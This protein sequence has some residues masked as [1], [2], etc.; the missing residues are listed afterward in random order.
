[1]AQAYADANQMFG[2]IVKVTP[3]S[4]VVGDMALMMVAQ[5]LSRAQVEDPAVDVA[6]PDSVADMLRGNLGQPPGGWPKAI[7]KKVLKGEKAAVD[8]PGKHLAAVDLEAARTNLSKE[9]LGFV[10]DDEDLNGYLMYPKVFLDYMGRHRIYGPVRAL[11]TPAFFYGMQPGEEITAEIAPGKTLEIRLQAVGET[12]D[13][14][15]AKVFFELNGQPRVIKV[16]NRA[17]KAKTASRPKAKDGN[18]L[19]VGA[20][21]P[22]VVA[23]LAVT[24]GQKVAAGDML[25]TI[26]AMKM[27]T[28]IHAE[29]D[30]V[31][32]AVHV[33]AGAQIDAKDLLIEFSE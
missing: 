20:P 14:G 21:M 13:A 33:H 8:R 27:E 16:P 9:L 17:V 12:D 18:L 23:S 24:A 25:L 26:E 19:H 22:G 15:D 29:R 31:V 10:I 5:N 32:K 7:Q 4:K 1:V 28:G 3:S 6:F 30:G 11:P 2:D